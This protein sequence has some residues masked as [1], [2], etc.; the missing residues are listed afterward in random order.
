MV[1]GDEDL[2]HRA[3][4]NLV[5]NALQAMVQPGAVTVSL[6]RLAPAD[7]PSGL[8]FHSDAACIEVRDVGGGIAPEIFDRLFEPFI[9]TKPGGSG[10]GLAI[11]HRAIEAH[12]GVVLVDSDPAGTRFT[13]MIPLATDRPGVTA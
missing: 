2:L 10:L 12:R 13:V 5:L 1:E 7:Q 8:P 3:C 4:F 6:R 11:V 9:T